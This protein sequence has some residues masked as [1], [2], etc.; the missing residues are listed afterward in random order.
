M[1]LLCLSNGHGED[2]IA[3][4]ILKAL[5]TLAPEF[6]VTPE[7]SA[8]P[9][10]GEGRA[11]EPLDLA[12]IA[13]VKTMPSGGFIYMDGK[14]LA[15]DMRGGLVQ[16]TCQQHRAVQAWAKQGPGL[17][18]CVGDVVPL[19]FGWLSGLPYAFVGTAKS[20]YYLRDEQGILP[21]RL[22]QERLTIAQGS[23]YGPVD[24]W[25]MRHRR[26]RGVFPRDRLTTRV[27]QQFQIAAI[28]AGNPMMD[29]LV[30]QI[31]PQ[32]A[33]QVVSQA[34]ARVSPEPQEERLK[35]LLLPGSRVP[36]AYDNWELL[37]TALRSISRPVWT[38]ET[39]F[40]RDRPVLALVAIAPT[41]DLQALIA[42]LERTSW[43]AIAPTDPALQ[44]TAAAVFSQGAMTIALSQQA[45]VDYAHW[46]DLGVAMAGTATEQ[47]VG[48]GKPV[49]TF[50]GVGPQF[51]AA[52]AE[53][54]SRLLG[55]SITL[56]SQPD[57]VGR[58]VEALL[59]DPDRLRLIA[60]NGQQRMGAAGAAARIARQLLDWSAT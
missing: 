33:P 10:V 45:F 22:Q 29:D 35:V 12:I 20:E 23:V 7:I 24:R 6:Q 39:A 1:R 19:A 43:Q 3:V 32:V 27:L 2:Q 16:L 36:E 17:V 21:N 58:A 51:T 4:R 13:P 56:V 49:I 34:A 28:D 47:V 41:V 50:P 46:A 30:P 55:P 9:I 40:E 57:E 54:Q 60:E 52:F 15:R 25:L 8:L 14:Q 31:A 42:P 5:K 48:L 59:Q 18:L 37:L 11:Y 26:C 38:G 53:A 44:A